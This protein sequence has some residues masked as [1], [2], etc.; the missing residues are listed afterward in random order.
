MVA[1]AEPVDILV[2]DHSDAGTSEPFGKSGTKEPL[3]MRYV[4]RAPKATRP[5]VVLEIWRDDTILQP[6]GG[7]NK[8]HRKR[9]HG[10]G[11][12]Q[13]VSRMSNTEEGGAVKQDRLVIV[14]GKTTRLP[15]DDAEEWQPFGPALNP[16]TN[17]NGAPRAMCNLLRP[18]GIPPRAY[19]EPNPGFTPPHS[20]RDPMP[21]R[22]GIFIKTP[23]GMR[24]TF[25]DELAKAL[26]V[27][28]A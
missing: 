12:T 9:M 1:C 16:E 13:Q 11:F 14:Y 20:L 18:H 10:L 2:T 4:E 21:S 24:R 23:K 19:R 8:A 22:L 6:H 7:L 25:P 27:P 5:T 17:K 28:S 15:D 26:G 3:W